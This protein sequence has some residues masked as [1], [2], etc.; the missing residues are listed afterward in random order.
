MQQFVTAVQ[1]AIPQRELEE[2][3][4]FDI[5]PTNLLDE[6]SMLPSLQGSQTNVRST[7]NFGA[8]DLVSDEQLRQLAREI[9]TRNW[10]KLAVT[11]GFLEYDIEAYKIKNNNDSTAA[12]CIILSYQKY[13]IRDFSIGI[14]II[15]RMA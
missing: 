15:T 10:S 7:D 9:S 4:K 13:V 3:L 2:M 1:R 14:R 11:L 6:A 8:H 12:V 5:I